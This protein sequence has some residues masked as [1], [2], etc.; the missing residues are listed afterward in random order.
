MNINFKKKGYKIA[1]ISFIILILFFFSVFFCTN[2]ISNELEHQL[3]TNLIDVANQNALAISNQ[4]NDNYMLLDSLFA[5]IKELPGDISGNVMLL[6][7]FV[8]ADNLKRVT[9]CTPD[10]TAY[11]T[12]NVGTNLSYREFFK[13]GL[14]GKSTITGVLTDALRPDTDEKIIIFSSPMYDDTTNELLGVFGLVYDAEVINA[15]LQVECF[16]GQGCSFATNEAGDIFGPLGRFE[17]KRCRRHETRAGCGCYAYGAD[18]DPNAS[19]NRQD[20]CPENQPV[21]PGLHLIGGFNLRDD[22]PRC[23]RRGEPLRIGVVVETSSL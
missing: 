11:T 8:K 10:G 5:E 17:Y 16:E 14:Q 13:R 12:D 20:G 22:T 18:G 15:S 4:L 1:L 3:E 6:K 21:Q 7:G 19:E 9:Y 2:R 23:L